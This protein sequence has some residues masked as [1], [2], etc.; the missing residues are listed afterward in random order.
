[1]KENLGQNV[2]NESL[3]KVDT[4]REHI[5]TNR[6]NVVLKK[7][8][9]IPNKKKKSLKIVLTKIASGEIMFYK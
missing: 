7:I 8:N 6:R 2:W 4:T 5:N 9:R 3:N 1:M